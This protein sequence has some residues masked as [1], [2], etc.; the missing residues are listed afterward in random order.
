MAAMPLTPPQPQ[1]DADP[2]PG[3]L[4]ADCRAYTAG[5][6]VDCGSLLASLNALQAALIDWRRATLLAHARDPN[7]P[8]PPHLPVGEVVRRCAAWLEAHPERA[9]EPPDW[10]L[11]DVLPGPKRV[12]APSLPISDRR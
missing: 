11:Q 7:H 12:Q 10:M 1:L 5:D 8:A 3:G 9:N 2:V 4:A 6:P